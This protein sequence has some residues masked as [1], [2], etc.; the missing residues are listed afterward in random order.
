MNSIERIKY[1]SETIDQESETV[2]PEVVPSQNWP[3]SIY[4]RIIIIIIYCK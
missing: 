3:E 4:I 2:K 1:Y